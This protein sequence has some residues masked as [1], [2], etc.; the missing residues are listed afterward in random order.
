MEYDDTNRGV[1]FPNDRKES[2]KHPDVKGNINVD[3]TEYWISGWK[4][5]TKKGQAMMSLS[6]RR[7]DEEKTVNAKAN[8][9]PH[10][11]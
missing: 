11:F 5:Q 7:K 2:D 10:P 6:V 1:L 3:G 4:T 9:D 8:R